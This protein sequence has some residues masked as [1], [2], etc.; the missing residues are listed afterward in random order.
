MV[1]ELKKHCFDHAE[2]P[3]IRGVR[4]LRACGTQFVA[5]KV[6][7]LKR[8]VDR[9][10]AYL[11]HLTFM[12]EDSSI[13]SVN[14]Q[15]VTGYLLKWHNCK[16]LLGCALFFDILKPLSILCKVLQEDEICVVHTIEAVMKTKN[17]LETLKTQPLEELSTI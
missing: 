11:S 15:K 13:K 5:H 9:F 3:T 6:A 14:R 8:V 17:C 16:V 1:T 4:P 12:T 2:I 10:G 7:A